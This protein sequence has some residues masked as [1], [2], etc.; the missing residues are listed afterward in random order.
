MDIGVCK[1]PTFQSKTKVIN[2]EYLASMTQVTV[3]GLPG[4]IKDIRFGG[5]WPRRQEMFG[6]RRRKWEQP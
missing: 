2:K 1:K 4:G 5:G 6:K 3:S